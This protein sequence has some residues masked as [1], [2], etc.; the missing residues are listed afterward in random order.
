MRRKMTEIN[1][2]ENLKRVTV[3]L[4][5]D[6]CP[7]E[8]SKR[9]ELARFLETLSLQQELLYCGAKIFERVA[10]EHD[11]TK[12]LATSEALVNKGV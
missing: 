8:V 12:W 5:S 10:I 2:G 3:R 9:K 1:V 11:G 6:E 7:D 4:E